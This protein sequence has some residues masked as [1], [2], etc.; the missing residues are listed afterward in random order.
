MEQKSGKNKIERLSVVDQVADLIKQMIVSGELQPG[1]K[2]PS[3]SDIAKMYTVNRLS[4]RMAL[5]K[6]ATLGVIETRVGEGSF[7]RKFS[8]YPLLNEIS[9]YYDSENCMEDIQQMRYL[10]ET[11]SISN[12]VR[13]ASESELKIL[14]QRLDEYL[15]ALDRSKKQNSK[16]LLQ[17]FVE[18]DFALHA[19]IVHM[20]HNRLFEEVYYMIQSLTMAHIERRIRITNVLFSEKMDED[21]HISLCKCIVEGDAEGAKNAMGNIINENL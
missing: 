2:L 5:Q 9:D 14:R 11:A 8:L 19:Q 4:V 18:S 12:A 15:V 1:D 13:E 10:I 17:R 7:V 20:S 6:L 3:E 21:Y 16:T